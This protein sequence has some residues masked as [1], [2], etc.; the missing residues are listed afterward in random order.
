MFS[1]DLG[2]SERDG[3]V[4]VALHGELDLAHAAPRLSCIPMIPAHCRPACRTAYVR[5]I[6]Q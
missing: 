4:V 2:T 6:G 3:T 5:E 1:A